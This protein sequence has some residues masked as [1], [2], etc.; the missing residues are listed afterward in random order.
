MGANE[1]IADSWANLSGWSTKNVLPNQQFARW[2]DFVNEAHLHWAIQRESYDSF[3]AFIRD[4]R[5]GDFRMVNLTAAHPNVRGVRGPAEIAQDKEALY[6]ILYIASGSEC[7]IIDGREIELLPG[8]FVVW[9]STRPMTFI[10]GEKL[11]QITLAVSHDRLHRVLPQVSDYVG[12][13][14]IA[15]SGLNRLFAE[16]ILSLD[17]QFGEL[18]RDRADS[19]LD[20][21]L[22]MLAITI[23]AS[24]ARNNQ[25]SNAKLFERVKNYIDKNLDDF[26]LSIAAVAEKNGISARHLHRLFHSLDTTAANYIMRRRLDRCRQELSSPAFT[27]STITDIAFRWGFSDS[28]TFSKVFRREFNISPRDFRYSVLSGSNV[29]TD[30]HDID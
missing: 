18:P 9:D 1:M 6:N 24:E 16:H 4:G 27:R 12:K 15:K 14:I 2:C 23:G 28:S 21:T 7:L 8:N 30:N 29:N 26:D 3:P 22:N 10:T 17:N 11:H 5:F 25:T 19:I 13:P 20:A